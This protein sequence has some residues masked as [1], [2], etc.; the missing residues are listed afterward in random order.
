MTND[1][2]ITPC[3]QCA[4]LNR[5]HFQ[6]IQNNGIA[7]CGKCKAQLHS[8]KNIHS[9]NLEQVRKIILN[10]PLPVVIDF[11]APWC[12]P[13]LSFAPTYEKYASQYPHD[14]LYLKLDTEANSDAGAEFHIRSIPTLAV[15]MDEKEKARQSGALPLSSLKAWLNSQGVK[16]T[17]D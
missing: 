12:G 4:S 6:T 10:S 1:S 3:P 2:K 13:C 7:K 15:F 11:W 9:V 8:E 5:I 16:S 17:T 14:A